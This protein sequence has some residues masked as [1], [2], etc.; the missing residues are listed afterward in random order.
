MLGIG[1]LVNS[2]AILIG[3]G[4]G[5]L[6]KKGIPD[7]FQ[8]IIFTATGTGV[9]LIGLCGVLTAALSAAHNGEI[10][11][12]WELML[13]LSLVLGG[14]MG[15]LLDID[16][17]FNRVGN[18]VKAQ[19]QGAGS[20]AGTGFVTATILFCAGAM[21][22]IGAIQDSGGN[23]SILYT[24][25]VID[26]ITAMIFTAVYG[27]TVLLAAFSVLVYQGAITILAI[28]L[29]PY[30]PAE[31]I[32]MMSLVGS[33]VLMLIAF[34]LWDIKTFKVANLIPAMFMPIILYWIPFLR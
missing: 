26:G 12:R 23:P 8:K 24:K 10:T 17:A 27:V 34:T 19:F 25:A 30:I 14:L 16:A 28:W 15:E 21:A 6:L 4:A 33:A 22:I 2:A 31:I 13:L 11:S 1:T 32:T 3:G 9:F 29:T 18:K 5:I 7:R 20:D